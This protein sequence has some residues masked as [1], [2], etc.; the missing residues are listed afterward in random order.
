VPALGFTLVPIDSLA[1]RAS[2]AA[3][4][5][6]TAAALAAPPLI[7]LLRRRSIGDQHEKGDSAELDRLH[8]GKAGTP[9]LGGVLIVGGAL[10]AGLL[11]A[12]LDAFVTISFA[13]TVCTLA[14][15]GLSDDLAK[16]TTGGRGMARRTKLGL[17]VA[18][19]LACGLAAYGNRLRVAEAAPPTRARATAAVIVPGPGLAPETTTLAPHP[20]PAGG[21]LALP[22]LGRAVL[23]LGLAYV[24]LA[25]LM[26]VSTTNATN[27]TD[28]LDGLCAGTSAFPLGALG[29]VAWAVSTPTI[30]VHTGIGY[31]PEA[32]DACV[33]AAA[34]LGAL[35]GFL[36][37]NAHPA[38]IFM[39]DT[40]SLAV[41]GALCCLAL[42]CRAELFLPLAGGV[43]VL[44][45]ASVVLQIG[46]F[47]LTGGRRLFRIAPIHHHFQFGG[48]TETQVTTRFWIVS[49]AL[50]A[51]ALL[52][53][54]VSG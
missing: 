16:L 26:L 39:G 43:L 34:T 45:A 47:K 37:H 22:F 42:A 28:G 46:F 36:W 53:L 5:A 21:D 4:T 6:F 18:V 31:V 32:A 8:A 12:R 49:A 17:L 1:L 40:G 11:F 24:A 33:L 10:L 9:T 13:A 52:G 7:R 38:R 50:S 25:M 29:C 2:A 23:P 15:I 48:L 54:F 14:L 30:A 51:A 41:G 44:E 35:V 3:V 27:F 19:G 20:A